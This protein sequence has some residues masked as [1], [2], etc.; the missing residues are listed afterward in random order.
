MM[1]I[2][3]DAV[4]NYFAIRTFRGVREQFY[5]DLA[6]AVSDSEPIAK[7]IEVRKARALKQKDSLASL[8]TIWLR[9]MNKRGGK[10]SYMLRGTVPESDIFVLSAIEDKGD[11]A[12]GL[13]FLAKTIR[14]QRGMTAALIGAI[15]M[16]IIVS[17]IMVGFMVVL[18][19]FVVPVFV[20]IAPVEKWNS[21]GKILYFVSHAITHYGLF[22][23]IGASALIFGFIWTLPNWTGGWRAIADK[24]LP[25]SVYRDYHGALFLIALAVMMH[26]G[27]TLMR[28]LE[29]LKAR[30]TPWLRW[31]IVR[32]IK[33]VDKMAGNYGESFSTGVF[34]QQLTNRI[35]DYS[36]RS[37]E[38]DKV[39][40]RIGIDGIERVRKDVESGA[41]LMNSILIAV[42][43]A[44][45]AFMLVGTILTA[46]GLS[47]SLKKE[48]SMQKIK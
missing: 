43:G 36:R 29:A 15:V 8:Y 20:E 9:R 38:L 35:V 18:A 28:A 46:Q 45:L 44:L 34:S 23:L 6:E 19:L 39:I 14:D 12:E 5:E 13:R 10:L 2:N 48:V 21:I 41:K 32:I 7:F 31:H 3:F 11:L 27:D 26:S 24:H 42:L 40:S 25:Y 33:N 1:D 47:E 37:S 30:S 17:V 22:L 4:G 16:P